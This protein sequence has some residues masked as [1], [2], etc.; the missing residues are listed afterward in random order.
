MVEM[1]SGA[2]DKK[3]DQMRIMASWVA[4]PT[5]RPADFWRGVGSG[6]ISAREAPIRPIA[7]S[8]PVRVTS[9]SA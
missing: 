3:V 8:A 5:S 1:D 6:A 4:L 9:A 2:R 7:E